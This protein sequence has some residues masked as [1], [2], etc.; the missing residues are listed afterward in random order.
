MLFVG[1]MIPKQSDEDQIDT[2]PYYA[3]DFYDYVPAVK[4]ITEK[5]ELEQDLGRQ[6]LVLDSDTDIGE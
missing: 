4:Q 1:F 3:P 2:K 6:V 5:E